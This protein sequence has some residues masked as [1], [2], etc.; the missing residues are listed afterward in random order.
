MATIL[1]NNTEDATF[2]DSEQQ[3]DLGNLPYHNLSELFDAIFI[4]QALAQ[5][6]PEDYV[7]QDVP[8]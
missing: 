4:E 1:I 3:Y 6:Y 2:N 8:Q 7:Q 5:Q